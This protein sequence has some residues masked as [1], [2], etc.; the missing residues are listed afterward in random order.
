[1]WELHERR[2][3]AA[4]SSAKRYRTV[5]YGI[6][7]FIGRY[8]QA[9]MQRRTEFE[10]CVVFV[11]EDDVNRHACISPIATLPADFYCSFFIKQKADHGRNS[12][13]MGVS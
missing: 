8:M 11:N 1:M 5:G 9:N 3:F 2:E 13:D 7:I 12:C 6:C 4:I 10:S